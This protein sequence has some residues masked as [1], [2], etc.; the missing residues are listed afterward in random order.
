MSNTNIRVTDFRKNLLKWKQLYSAK[1]IFFS[2]LFFVLFCRKPESL[3]NPQFFA[4]DGT[5]WFYDAYMGNMNPFEKYMEYCH[6]IPRVTSVIAV[7]ISLKHTPFIFNLTS[8]IIATYC[9]L[10]FSLRRF[11]LV[12]KNDNVRKCICLLFVINPVS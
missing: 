4:E 9:C 3:L 12:I 11:R 10:Y 8:I 5:E 1:F 2:L 7:N 6:L